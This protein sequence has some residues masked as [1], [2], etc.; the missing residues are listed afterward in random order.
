LKYLLVHRGHV[1]LWSLCPEVTHRVLA[2]CGHVALSEYWLAS[3]RH[4]RPQTLLL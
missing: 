4:Y 3:V 1:T 2:D